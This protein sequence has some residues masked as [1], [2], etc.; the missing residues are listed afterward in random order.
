MTREQAMA[1]AEASRE[2]REIP[3]GARISSAEQQYI[4][5]SQ[6]DPEQPSPV[7]DV[8]AWLVRFEFEKGRWMELAVDDKQGQVVRVRRSR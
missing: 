7:R 1:V 3:R 4:E 6:G 8:L 2:E 5:L